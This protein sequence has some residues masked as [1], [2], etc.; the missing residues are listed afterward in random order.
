MVK[1]TI[2]VQC[3]GEVGRGVYCACQTLLFISLTMIFITS[4]CAASNDVMISELER[5]QLQSSSAKSQW[6]TFG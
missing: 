5:R 1:T 6:R 2:S 4:V 3:T